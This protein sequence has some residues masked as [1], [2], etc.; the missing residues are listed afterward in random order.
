MEVNGPAV[1]GTAVGSPPLSLGPGFFGDSAGRAVAKQS[2]S[3][4]PGTGEA[5]GSPGGRLQEARILA[6]EPLCTRGK[7]AAGTRVGTWG[8]NSALGP[9]PAPTRPC[10]RL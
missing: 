2:H 4:G 3:L 5:A 7:L 9:G 10:S 1:Q 8:W 6:P